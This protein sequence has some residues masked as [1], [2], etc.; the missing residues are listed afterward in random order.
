MPEPLVSRIDVMAEADRVQ[1]GIEP[2]RRGDD[3]ITGWHVMGFDEPGVA[4]A[5]QHLEAIEVGGRDRA[6]KML[7]GEERGL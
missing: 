2:A 3:D 1:V 6:N 7:G 5:A 4:V